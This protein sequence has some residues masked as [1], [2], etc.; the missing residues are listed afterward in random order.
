MKKLFKNRNFISFIIFIVLFLLLCGSFGTWKVKHDKDME[1]EAKKLEEELKELE[2]KLNSYIEK[3]E[4]IDIE[5]IKEDKEKLEDAKS[6]LNDLLKEVND[7]FDDNIE[8]ER[9]I[10][11]IDKIEEKID[12]VD[13]Y[14]SNLEENTEEVSSEIDTEESNTESENTEDSDNEE[15]AN[16]NNNNSNNGN[17]ENNKPNTNP[18]PSPDPEPEPTPEPEPEPEEPVITEPFPE[19]GTATTTMPREYNGVWGWQAAKSSYTW[20]ALKEGESMDNGKTGFWK[21]AGTSGMVS[22]WDDW[23]TYATPLIRPTYDGTYDGEEA[24]VTVWVWLEK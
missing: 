1:R 4:K 15:T 24:S 16:N 23:W 13:K 9:V 14:I 10:D 3:L 2:E 7:E 19:Y 17:S 8:D 21:N 20:Y 22:N 5:S 18:S 12:L 11:L 6:D